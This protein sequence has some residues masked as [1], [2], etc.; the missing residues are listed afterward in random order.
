MDAHTPTGSNNL[1]PTQP[2]DDSPDSVGSERLNRRGLLLLGGALAGGAALAAC[3]GSESSDAKATTTTSTKAAGSGSSTSASTTA[4]ADAA[5]ST[6]GTPTSTV[7]TAADFKHLEVCKLIPEVMEGPFPTKV[8]M[9]RRNITEGHVGEPLRV[10]IQVVD[11]ACKPIPGAKVEVWHCDVDGDYSSYVDGAAP[12]DAGEGTTFLR[13][14]QT[15]NDQGVVEFVTIWPGWYPGRAI[16]I[17][18]KVHVDDRTVLTTQYLFDD[19]LNSEVMSSGVY[20]VHGEPDTKNANDGVTGGKGVPDG[21]LF[22]VSNDAA[23]SGRRGVIVVGIDPAATS[24]ATGAAPAAPGAAGA[25]PAM[26]PPG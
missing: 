18:S 10:G 8:Q 25:A 11:K 16:H 2:G 21:L 3:S 5:A 20:A 13:G 7:F 14:T 4:V 6:S 24:S 17:H 15:T 22:A 23:L 19:A 1:A 26:A 12:D 9:E